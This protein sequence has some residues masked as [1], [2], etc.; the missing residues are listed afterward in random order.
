MAANLMLL[1]SLPQAKNL[2]IATLKPFCS[3]LEMSLIAANLML[4]CSLLQA[5]NQMIAMLKLFCSHQEMNSIAANL[6][7]FWVWWAIDM[8]S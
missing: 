3:H 1:R 8:S 5:K 2:M 6:K 7:L 4:L